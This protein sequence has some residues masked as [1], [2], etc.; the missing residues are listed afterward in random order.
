ML[1]SLLPL[2]REWLLLPVNDGYLV[3]GNKAEVDGAVTDTRG[4]LDLYTA[5]WFSLIVEAKPWTGSGSDEG[6]DT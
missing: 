2:L 3:Q 4:S 1:A 5:K 6:Q